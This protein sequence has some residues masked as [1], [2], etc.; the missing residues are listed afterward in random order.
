MRQLVTFRNAPSSGDPD[1]HLLDDAVAR[2]VI[3]AMRKAS[4]HLR[5]IGV[6]HML[7]GGLAVGAYGWVRATK[8][9]DFVIGP[10]GFTK[11]PS[12]LVF[13]VDDM[14][15]MVGKIAIDNLVPTDGDEHL[16]DLLDVAPISDG[17]PVAPI[18]ALTVMKLR[19]T[20]K[21]DEA[22]LVELWKNAVLDKDRV[23][24]Y[25]RKHAPDLLEKF[26][27]ILNQ[28]DEEA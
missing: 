13:F 11:S 17:I 19:S 18:E 22:D 9:V 21:K 24:A 1:I 20:R 6:R 28:A 14:P 26:D 5:S 7:I 15:L 3:E 10:E 12:G 4:E 23:V 16:F 2:P 25:L 27:R 8:D